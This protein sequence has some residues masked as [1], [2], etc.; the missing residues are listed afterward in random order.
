MVHAYLTGPE[1]VEDRPDDREA[2]L[3]IRISYD[4]YSQ[5]TMLKW[6]FDL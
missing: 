3:P 5:Q 4:P 1:D 6:E 2:A